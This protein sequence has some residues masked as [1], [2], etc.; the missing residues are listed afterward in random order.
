[1]K[2]HLL[3]RKFLKRRKGREERRKE[4]KEGRKEEHCCIGLPNWIKKKYQAS[5]EKLSS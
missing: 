1:M 5:V 2:F 3:E 4:K